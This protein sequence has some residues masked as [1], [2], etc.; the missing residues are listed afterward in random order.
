MVWSHLWNNIDLICAMDWEIGHVNISVQSGDQK[1]QALIEAA[2]K[3]TR[4]AGEGVTG[5]P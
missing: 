5:C 1:N 3:I 2:E 4:E